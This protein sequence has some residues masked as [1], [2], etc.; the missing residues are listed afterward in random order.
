[1]QNYYGIAIRSNTGN[2]KAMKNNVLA[3]TLSNCASNDKHPWHSTYCPPGKDS[4]CGYMR[5]KVL[6]PTKRF[7][8]QLILECSAQNCNYSRSFYTSGTVHNGKA[9]VVNRRAVLAGRNIGIGHRGL[10]KFAGTMNMPPPMNEN[11]YR[12]HVVAI[13]AAAEEVCKESTN[14][15][16]QETKQFYEVEE[17]G[18]YIGISADGTWTQRGF[19]SCRSHVK[20]V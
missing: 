13:H 18:N 6:K 20:R 4:W 16:R 3:T 14:H 1:M 9:F 15:A 10:S 12:D 19:S 5:D 7:A 11:A 2:L 17:D 8:S